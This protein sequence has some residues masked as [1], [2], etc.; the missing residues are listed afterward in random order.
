MSGL[1]F[2]FATILL[3]S[4]GN[5]SGQQLVSSDHLPTE[6]DPPQRAMSFTGRG[7]GG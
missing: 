6:A 7:A 2:L 4:L 1:F 5:A 3:L